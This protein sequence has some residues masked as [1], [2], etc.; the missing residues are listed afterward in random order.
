MLTSLWLACVFPVMF[1]VV[2]DAEGRDAV[3]MAANHDAVF[4]L[5][6]VRAV[7]ETRPITAEAGYDAVLRLDPACAEAYAG[8]GVARLRQGKPE[9][10]P[11]LERAVALAPG[12]AGAW[13]ARGVAKGDAGDPA[14]AAMD[15][16]EALRH[17]PR[18]VAVVG[19]VRARLALADHNGV[20]SAAAVGLA[21]L[22]D[23]TARAE[24]L[25]L[26]SESRARRGDWAGALADTGRA[27]LLA[28]ADPRHAAARG[29]A[30]CRL[31]RHAEA[32]E[33]YRAALTTAPDF[34][35]A[36]H[37]LAWLLATC[38]DPTVRDGGAAV[39]IARDLAARTLLVADRVVLA[40][41]LAECGDF[42]TAAAGVRELLR[43]AP[44]PM[45]GD[46]RRQLACYEARTPW[47]E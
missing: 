37:R 23:D 41:A 13:E 1:P 46:L 44:E 28:P 38:P 31:N 14:G 40:A 29:D 5:T 16:L 17:E 47:R 11:D 30:L 3:V 2:H 26:R 22:P 7:A 4:L 42:A 21:L 35:L 8:R 43:D 36:R 20:E 34:A 39:T 10:M 27:G 12:D 25:G 33:E 15:F 9:G 24:L 18:P 19:L 6:L 32:A 45:A